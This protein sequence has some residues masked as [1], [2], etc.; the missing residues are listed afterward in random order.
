MNL[1]INRNLALESFPDQRAA[2]RDARAEL[3][4]QFIPA[5]ARV[6]DLAGIPTLAGL[7]PHGC[8]YRAAP[9]LPVGGDFPTA[10]A[11]DTDIIVM[12]GGLDRVLD[13]ESLFTHLRFCRQDV[14]LSYRARDFAGGDRFSFYELTRLF[15]RYAFRIACTAPVDGSEMIIRLT[16]MERLKPVTRCS[17]AVVADAGGFSGRLG[18]QMV[19]SLLPGEAELHHLSFD[20]LNEAREQYDLVVLGA[21]T[22]LF[23]PLIGDGLLDIIRRGRAAIGIFGTQY[24]ELIP[25]APLGR[26]IERLD[27]WFARYQDDVLI[28]GRGSNVVHLGDWLIDRF[29]LA[30]ARDDAPLE[31]GEGAG[32][33]APDETI[34]AIQRHKQVY[35][36]ALH[37]FL[38]ALTSA[39]LA[40]YSEAPARGLA[41]AASGSFRSLLIDVFGRSYPEKQFFLVDRDAVARYKAQVHANVAALRRRVEGV[42]ANV[43]VAAV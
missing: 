27:C 5:G 26:L 43:S 1:H 40:A 9:A 14:I 12:L 11:A 28:Y 31:I 30:H 37:P 41:G 29:P 18:L 10:L 20:R 25:R 33:L 13:L 17:V 39:E 15:D 16:P 21:G 19:Q 34:A 6:L 3:A 38:C 22:G 7:L 23:Q 24:R 32:D 2:A 36:T 4:A 35:S 8:S 42:L